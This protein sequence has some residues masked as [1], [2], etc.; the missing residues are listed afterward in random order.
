VIIS[1]RMRWARLV[2]H[3]E[4]K[5]NTYCF[6]LKTWRKDLLDDLAIMGR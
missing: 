5:R 4:E 2:A 6:G 1:R 3:K